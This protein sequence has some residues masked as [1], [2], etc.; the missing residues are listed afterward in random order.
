MI[1]V[2]FYLVNKQYLYRSLGFGK[3]RLVFQRSKHILVFFTSELVVA[4]LFTLRQ[5]TLPLKLKE[6]GKASFDH[7]SP[8]VLKFQEKS[9]NNSQNF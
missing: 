1:L 7:W 4:N 6:N 3:S 5:L 2:S 9:L 8:G